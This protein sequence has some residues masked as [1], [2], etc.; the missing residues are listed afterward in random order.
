MSIIVPG[1][2]VEAY[3]GKCLDSLLYQDISSSDYEIIVVNDG[4]TDRTKEIVEGYVSSHSNVILINQQNKGLSCAR[5]S[6]VKVA[7]GSYV[8]YI[9]SDDYIEKNVLGGLLAQA[10]RD[11]LDVLRYNY[12]NVNED[13]KVI[14]PKRNNKLYVDY[15]S[16]VTDGFSFLT[17]RLG[18]A[19]YAWQFLIKVEIAK[20]VLFK[21][22]IYFEDTEWA[23]RMLN[24]AKRV[25]STDVVVY[26]Y[27]KRTNSITNAVDEAK[28]RKVIE[29][30]MLLVEGLRQQSVG[31]VD[32]SWYEGM[33]AHTVLSIMGLVAIQ[34]YDERN[35]YI[36]RLKR[37]GVFPLSLNRSSLRNKIKLM[38]ISV[39]P[40]FYCRLIRK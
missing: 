39:F 31:K 14:V 5:N 23:P 13:Y 21:E 18:Y 1:Q 9:D 19:C 36:S 40:S 34:Y 29:D 3:I 26:N 35:P 37:M 17:H 38:M 2:N 16:D 8:M 22:G 6:G 20:N 11:N 32:K 24:K 33:I 28:K 25:A 10:E 27:M 4:S 12:R 15:S 7:R 30:K